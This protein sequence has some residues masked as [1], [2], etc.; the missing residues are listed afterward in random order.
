M[1]T[2]LSAFVHVCNLTTACNNF[3]ATKQPGFITQSYSNINACI[4][5]LSC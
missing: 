1:L 5:L 4:S 2:G 3:T